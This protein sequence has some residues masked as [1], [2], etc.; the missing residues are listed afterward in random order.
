MLAGIEQQQAGRQA[1][2]T[3]KLAGLPSGPWRRR[4]EAPLRLESRQRAGQ[5]LAQARPELVER[6]HRAVFFF[7]FFTGVPLW[8]LVPAGLAAFALWPEASASRPMLKP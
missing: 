2:V 3:R 6:F 1:G 5:P 7:F 8:A 4:H